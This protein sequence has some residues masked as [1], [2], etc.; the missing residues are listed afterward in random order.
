MIA[1]ALL[2]VATIVAAVLLVGSYGALGAALAALIGS[3]VGMFAK[4]FTLD[5]LLRS[6][7]AEAT[8]AELA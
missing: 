5:R 4:G 3:I 2:M 6:I 7:A 8:P 1:D